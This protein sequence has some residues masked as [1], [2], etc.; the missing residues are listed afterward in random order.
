MAT[1]AGRGR[2][3][4][5]LLIVVDYYGAAGLRVACIGTA[6]QRRDVRLRALAVV[7]RSFALVIQ[8]ELA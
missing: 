1:W 6:V 2:Q 7:A 3:A 5:D 8:V 4:T